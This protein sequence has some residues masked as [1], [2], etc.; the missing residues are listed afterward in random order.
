MTIKTPQNK[1]AGPIWGPITNKTQRSS[2]ADTQVGIDAVLAQ[3]NKRCCNRHG[4]G[5]SFLPANQNFL[6]AGIDRVSVSGLAAGWAASAPLM[7]TDCSTA[8]S[9]RVSVC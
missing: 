4:Y 6:F 1:T 5:P 3:I 9:G 2:Q 7:A 8:F